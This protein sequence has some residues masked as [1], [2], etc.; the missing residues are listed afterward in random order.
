MCAGGRCCIG[1]DTTSADAQLALPI[2]GVTL[3]PPHALDA[4]LVLCRIERPQQPD[5]EDRAAA[6]VKCEVMR[7][8]HVQVFRPALRKQLRHETKGSNGFESRST[9]MADN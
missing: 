2:S 1:R 5:A 6:A 4:V 9:R 7:H 3:P 8:R